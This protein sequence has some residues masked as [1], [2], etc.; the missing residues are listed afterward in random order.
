M[1]FLRNLGHSKQPFAYA[2]LLPL[3]PVLSLK[4]IRG[5]SK[6]NDESV[7]EKKEYAGLE[8]VCD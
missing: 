6:P 4:Q 7:L 8:P 3:D 2:D 1:S 5:I